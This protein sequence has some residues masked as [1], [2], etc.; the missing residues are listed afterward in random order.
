MKLR[1]KLKKTIGTN[2]QLFLGLAIGALIMLPTGVYVNTRNNSHQADQGS[3][4]L[5]TK[6]ATESNQI[7]N[8]APVTEQQNQSSA[9]IPKPSG[10][11][12]YHI[13]VTCKDIVIPYETQYYDDPYMYVGETK[14]DRAGTNGLKKDCTRTYDGKDWG[15]Y[16]GLVQKEVYTETY[17]KDAYVGRGTKPKPTATQ[18][19][20]PTYTYEQALQMAKNKCLPI[21]Q[22]SGTGS[23]AYQ[24]CLQTAL[25]TYGY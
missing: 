13:A 4:T 17:P 25:G 6:P 16:L 21:A 5:E 22:A 8:L 9:E 18:P 19:T 12:D 14:V 10:G 7:Q 20:N 24:V 23:S 15:K 2:K 3:T 1:A 11:G